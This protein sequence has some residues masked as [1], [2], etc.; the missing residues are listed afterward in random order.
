MDGC[1][2]VERAWVVRGGADRWALPLPT[3]DAD[4]LERMARGVRETAC[5]DQEMR[6]RLV[7][8]ALS[9]CAESEAEAFEVHLLGCE[10]CFQ[11]LK[12][13][14]RAGALLREFTEPASPVR[15]RLRRLL[16]GESGDR[17]VANLER[18][19]PRM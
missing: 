19:Q 7:L 17:D 16:R 3:C 12:C 4:W 15:D 18:L 10:D 2:C 1:R 9:G 8:Y 11:D 13:L 6:A 14:D 5:W